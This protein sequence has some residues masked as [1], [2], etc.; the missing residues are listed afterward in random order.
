MILSYTLSNKIRVS[1]CLACFHQRRD[2]RLTSSKLCLQSCC[3]VGGRSDFL[4]GE[5][6]AYTHSI[7]NGKCLNG[8]CLS[9][10]LLRSRRR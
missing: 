5:L 8:K 10:L 2:C 6:Y 4:G 1:Y 3:A 7:A 9:L